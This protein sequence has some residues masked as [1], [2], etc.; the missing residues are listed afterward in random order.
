MKFSGPLVLGG[1][2]ATGIEVPAAVVEAL[3]SGRRVPVVVTIGKH[4]YRTTIASMGGSFWI[5]VAAQER[6]A[7][8]IKAGDQVDVDIIVDVAPRTVAPPDDLAAA[9]KDD[10]QAQDFF[11]SLP[12]SHQKA[13]VTWLESAK[14]PET[15]ERRVR[16]AV[17]MLREQ[18]RR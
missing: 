2:T 9:M 5:P 3:N 11:A 6:E 13:Y 12:P 18:R 8:G 7:A 14:R 4:S 15:R 1:K 16:E 10:Q 17:A